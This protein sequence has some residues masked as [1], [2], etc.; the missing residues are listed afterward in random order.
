[1]RHRATTKARVSGTPEQSLAAAAPGLEYYLL[2]LPPVAEPV[3]D[4]DRDVPLAKQAGWDDVKT[5][6]QRVAQH[7]AT[8]L[9]KH[10]SA[11]MGAPNRKQKIF[12]DYLRNNRGSSTVAAY[13]ARARPGLGVSVPLTWDEVAQTTAGDQWT[14]ANLHERLAGVLLV[15]RRVQRLE[16]RAFRGGNRDLRSVVFQRVTASRRNSTGRNKHSRSRYVTFVDG[17]PDTDVAVSGTFGLYIPNRREAL[18][19]RTPG[20]NCRTRDPEGRRVLQQLHVVP[21]GGRHF[22][23]KKNV[24]VCIDQPGKDG[25]PAEVNE[26]RPL[27]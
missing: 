14:I 18:F 16:C 20:S 19:Q 22:A 1:L 17:L 11:K 21:A 8:T 9:P 26:L 23:L 5:F 13:S 24:S 15:P 6:S 10:F 7:M 25:G 12:V 2:D 4:R 3:E 27:W